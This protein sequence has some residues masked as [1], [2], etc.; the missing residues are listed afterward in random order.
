MNKDILQS[1]KGF[2]NSGIWDII[3]DEVFEPL[4]DNVKDVSIPFKIGDEIIEP[5]KAYLAKTLTAQKLKGVI[6]MFNRLQNSNIKAKEIN[7]E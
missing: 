4:L 6:D 5:E 2:A 3:R 1:L 7:F